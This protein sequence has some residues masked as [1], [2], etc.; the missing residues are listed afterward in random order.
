MT[1][2]TIAYGVGVLMIFILLLGYVLSSWR[3]SK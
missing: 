1:P 3:K 2:E